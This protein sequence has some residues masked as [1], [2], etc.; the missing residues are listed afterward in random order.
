MQA[1]CSMHP[2]RPPPFPDPSEHE[3]N[4]PTSL[5]RGEGRLG[6]GKRLTSRPTSLGRGEGQEAG[7]VGVLRW[8]WWLMNTRSTVIEV[9]LKLKLRSP[10]KDYV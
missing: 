9:D 1:Y 4:P 2:P 10:F 3:R 8:W 5:K 7:G 6:R